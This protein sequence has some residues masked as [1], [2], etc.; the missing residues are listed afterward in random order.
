MAVCVYYRSRQVFSLTLY[1]PRRLDGLPFA[2]NYFDFVRMNGMGL[3]VPEDEVSSNEY[4]A[5]Y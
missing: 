3:G 5:I 1:I 4:M 2:S